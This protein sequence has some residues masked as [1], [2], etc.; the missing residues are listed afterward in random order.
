MIGSGELLFVLPGHPGGTLPA[1]APF[2]VYGNVFAIA[3]IAIS[4]A[5]VTAAVAESLAGPD[6]GSFEAMLRSIPAQTPDPEPA[7]AKAVHLE[8]SP[9][10]PSVARS[11]RLIPGQPAISVTIRF[12]DHATSA[13]VGLTVVALKP[14]QFR[15]V[16]EVGSRPSAPPT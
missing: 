16:I 10:Q 15:V 14:D 3:G 2:I 4:T 12:D 13:P 9:P 8:M 1:S 5:Y 7:Y 6:A 11:L